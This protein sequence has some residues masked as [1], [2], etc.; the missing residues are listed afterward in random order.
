MPKVRHSHWAESELGFNVGGALGPGLPSL[1]TATLRE[2]RTGLGSFSGSFKEVRAEGREERKERDAVGHAQ[3]STVRS[4][5][6][7]MARLHL[8]HPQ[9]GTRNTWRWSPGRSLSV[10]LQTEVLSG[11]P[12][13]S[14]EGL[15]GATG[16]H[17]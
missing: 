2:L 6:R 10:G 1:P 13:P 4:V 3:H 5:G 11:L 7:A 17:S 14:W 15:L 12:G 9:Q 8:G 16:V